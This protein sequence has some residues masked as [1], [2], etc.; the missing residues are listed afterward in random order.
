MDYRC[1]LPVGSGMGL[2]TS[3]RTL[4]LSTELLTRF[5][6]YMRHVGSNLSSRALPGDEF[7]PEDIFSAYLT[8]MQEKRLPEKRYEDR[9][10]R[11]TCERPSPDPACLQRRRLTSIR[12]ITRSRDVLVYPRETFV[13]RRIRFVN[14]LVHCWRD[15]EASKGCL[16][17]LRLLQT[18][19]GRKRLI[20]SY[21]NSWWVALHHKDSLARYKLVIKE[22]VKMAPDTISL[23]ERGT[24]A[25]W[26]ES[27][28]LFHCKWDDEGSQ[29]TSTITR[30]L[31]KFRTQNRE[32]ED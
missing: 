12:A 15:G 25:D 16:F 4:T 28:R 1:R 32:Q 5:D 13:P 26:H 21:K 27:I 30:Y 29:T 7:A 6:G 17:A 23:V 2:T 10:E 31:E 9:E 24:D 8:V 11:R 18:A 14:E 22:I 20:P 3:L 19:E